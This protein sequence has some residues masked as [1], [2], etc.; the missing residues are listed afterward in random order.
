MLLTFFIFSPFCFLDFPKFWA[1]FQG[2]ARHM[3]VG[4]YSTGGGSQWGNYLSLFYRDHLYYASS[5]WTTIG[6][7]YLVGVVWALR[8]HGRRELV[9]LSYSLVYFLMVANFGVCN[10]RYI[11]PVFPGLAVL[12]G[13]AIAFLWKRSGEFKP[14]RAVIMVSVGI[15]AILPIRNIILNDVM[16]SRKDTRTEAK[17]WIENNIPE[18]SKIA[19]E[20]DNNGTVQLQEINRDIKKKIEG[21]RKGQLKTIHHTAAQMAEVHQMRLEAARGKKY[22]IIRI[23]EVEGLTPVPYLYNL[24]GLEKSGVEYLV[25]SSDVY[26]WFQNSK[27]REKYPLHAAFY[28]RIFRELK[29]LKVIRPENQPGPTMKIYKINRVSFEK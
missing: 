15:L 7:L 9:L 24:A 12:A 6:I 16:L 18:G 11:I 4:V 20:W 10:P 27:G 14:G 28:D 8:R 26:G 1:D 2:I 13:A 25:I 19:V 29:P 17:E 21:Y 5:R 3:R 23:G 22:D